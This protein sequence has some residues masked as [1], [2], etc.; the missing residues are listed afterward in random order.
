MYS[1]TIPAL[2]VLAIIVLYV[3][4]GMASTGSKARRKLPPGPPRLPF[5]GSLFHL[6]KGHDWLVYEQWGKKYGVYL[7]P[8]TGHLWFRAANFDD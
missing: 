8:Y 1:L 2:G 6:P 4:P 7:Q 3:W 5:V